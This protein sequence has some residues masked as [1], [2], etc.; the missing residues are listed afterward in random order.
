MGQADSVAMGVYLWE[1]GD[2]VSETMRLI[3]GVRVT[4]NKSLGVSEPQSPHL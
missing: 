2:G 3:L 1:Q 4:T